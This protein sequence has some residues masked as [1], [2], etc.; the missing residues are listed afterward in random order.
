MDYYN[1]RPLVKFKRAS[2]FY[3]GL[4]VFALIFTQAL[5]ATA[6]SLLFWFLI[7]VPIV[8]I[9]YVLIGKALIRIY[10][11][12]DISKVEKLQPVE[13]EM[14]II[15]ASPFAYPFIEAIISVPEEDGVR[16]TEQSMTLSLAPMGSYIVSHSTSFK[17]RGTY[18]IGVRCLYISDFLGL[19]SIRLDVD[20]YN[21][22]LVFPRK[23][24]MNMKMSTSATDIPNDS[25]KLVFSTEKAEVSN[26]REYIPGDSLKSIHWKLSS[27]IWDG[28]L[29]VKEFN[30]NTSQSVYM[31]CDFSRAIPPE[32]F[33]DEDA[34][35]EREKAEREA[36]KKPKSKNVKL[37]AAKP[38]KEVLAAEKAAKKAAKRAKSGMGSTRIGDAAAI[39]EMIDYAA[40]A[41]A[42]VR[43]K[44]SFGLFKKKAEST[45]AENIASDSLEAQRRKREEDT[46]AALAIGGVIKPE[47]A[48]DMDEFCADGVV[49]M[50]IGAVLNEL[51][52]GH[53]VTLIWT[54]RR[55]D[56]GIAAVQLTCPEDFDAVFPVF[57]TTPPC[58][59]K[60]NVTTLLPLI[61]ESLNVTIRIC[62]SNLD[63]LSVNKYAAIPGLFGGAGTGCVAEVLLFNPE[64]RYENVGIRREYVEMSRIRLAQD[65][66]DLTELK[67][68]KDESG[69]YT[70]SK[71]TH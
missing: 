25:A 9:A 38:S 5:R 8:S 56:G 62:T 21:N 66:V 14:R 52:G 42:P 1:K 43:E 20:I 68:A 65:G 32:V 34:R 50:A 36:A 53:D 24:G 6:S 69:H 60:E 40:D 61:A 59:E 11:G 41:K 3:L 46:K 67:A 2:I 23:L 64:E 26:I 45:E 44:K 33:E 58:S 15:N 49:E 17:Y 47:Y 57:A 70:L 51:R 16:C 19:F 35:I 4:L 22:V 54:D 28:G 12:S 13:Y 30:T 29:M 18:E 31:L 63:P 27:K 71:T 10:V 7:L 48:A 39:D 37:K 55:Q